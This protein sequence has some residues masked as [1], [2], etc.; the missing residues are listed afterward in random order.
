[1]NRQ[2][3]IVQKLIILKLELDLDPEPEKVSEHEDLTNGL[4]AG[5]V[6][7]LNSVMH[8]KIVLSQAFT[9]IMQDEQKF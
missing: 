9:M 6:E 2:W 4:D 7:L 8:N 3:E 5:L 1:M